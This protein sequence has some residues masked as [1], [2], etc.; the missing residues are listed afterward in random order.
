MFTR[1]T[2]LGFKR[3]PLQAFGFYLAYLLLGMLIGGVAAPLAAI[4]GLVD[5]G[6]SSGVQVGAAIVIP[7]CVATAIGIG[8][9]KGI[10]LEFKMLVFYVVTGI[11]AYLLGALLGMV[12]PA[13]MTTLDSVKTSH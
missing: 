9:K 7:L 8:V 1:L 5:F 2:D 10:A 13:Y 4:L 12:V 6:F 3:S 11:F